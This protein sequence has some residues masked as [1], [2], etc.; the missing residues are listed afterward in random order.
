MRAH[1]LKQSLEGLGERDCKMLEPF[2]QG[3]VG[4]FWASVTRGD[5]TRHR[6]V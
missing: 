2:N 4:V 5:G 1:D 3:H 6:P